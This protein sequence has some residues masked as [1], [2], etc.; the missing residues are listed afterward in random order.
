MQREIRITAHAIERYQERVDPESS[1]L[2]AHLAIRKLLATGRSRPTPRHWMRR[3]VEPGTT[4]IFS[5]SYPGVCAIVTDGRAVTIITRELARSA[6]GR[7]IRA[8]A[9]RPRLA[10]PP[11]PRYL[12]DDLAA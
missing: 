8:E 5:A 1:W 7:V 9:P 4:F 12:D 3:P 11:M 10:P 2:A 6:P